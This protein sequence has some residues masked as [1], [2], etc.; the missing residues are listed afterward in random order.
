VRILRVAAMGLALALSSVTAFADTEG[1][2]EARTLFEQGNALVEKGN[3][4]DGLEKF[5]AAYARWAN[6]KIL[7][8]IGTTLHQLG[9][10][11]E[12]ADTYEKYLNDPGA[13]PKRKPEVEQ[14][15]K[16]LEPKVGKLTI[17][18]KSGKTRVIVDGK[19]VGE[20][21]TSVTIRVEP[22]VHAIVGDREGGKAISQTV[23]VVAG[24]SKSVELTVSS[25]G[26]TKPPPAI[27]G[28]PIDTGAQKPV[29]LSH[30]GQLGLLVRGDIDGKGRGVVIVPAVTYGLGDYLE[31]G[32]GGLLGKSK[33]FEPMINALLLKGTFR[34]LIGAAMPTF[35]VDGARIGIR[36]GGGLQVDPNPHLGFFALASAVYFPSVPTD[37]DRTVF[38]VSIGAQTR[39]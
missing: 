28:A 36:G 37:Y 7:L 31:V 9:R 11:A 12:A 4:V 5:R 17:T 13:D 18:V 6:P 38:V 19:L 16:E 25:E 33:G 14:T 1:E 10:N 20:T 26:E 30:A 2:A 32:A 15:L 35:F 3:Y 21:E 34:L 27:P 24:D 23:A 39:F 8:N 29:N 22:G